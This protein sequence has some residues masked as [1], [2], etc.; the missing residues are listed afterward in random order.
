MKP[1]TDP[2]G[3]IRSFLACLIIGALPYN[4]LL[5]CL[6][7]QNLDAFPSSIMANSISDQLRSSGHAIHSATPAEVEG[8]LNRCVEATVRFPFRCSPGRLVDSSGQIS[9]RFAC[10][11]H[12]ERIAGASTEGGDIPVDNACAIIDFVEFLDI[13]G[14]RAAHQRSLVVK[15]LRR[16]ELPHI[17]SSPVADGTVCIIYAR[18][19]SVPIDLLAEE[20]S[21]LNETLEHSEWVDMIAIS[22]TAVVSYGCQFAGRSDIGDVLPPSK[23]VKQ[24]YSPAWYI[25]PT[26]QATGEGTFNKVALHI[27]GY[28]VFFVP[29]TLV[30]EFRDMQAGVGKTVITLAPYQY[31]VAGD[32]RLVPT[33]HYADRLLPSRPFLVEAA[34]SE[35]LLA[36]L[37]Y[38]P[39]QDGGVILLRGKLPLEGL[40]IFL[41]RE[42]LVR[43]G[44]VQS[45]PRSQDSYVLPIT[46]ADFQL[47]MERLRKQSN[48]VVRQVQPKYVMEKVADAGTTTPFM[49]RV[50]MGMLQLRGTAFPKDNEREE[51]DKAL[52][53][54]L[55]PLISARTAVEE[56]LRL[57]RTHM[58]DIASGRGVRITADGLEVVGD[59]HR[60]FRREIDSFLYDAAKALKE[61]MQKAGKAAGKDIGFLFQKQ[62]TYQN[63]LEALRSSDPILAQYIEKTRDR[64][65]ERLI[66]ARNNLDHGGWTL[67][68]TQY[69]VRNGTQII[70]HPPVIDGTPAAEFVAHML[71]RLSCFIEEFLTH[72]FQGRLPSGAEIT[73]IPIQWRAPQAP[74]R[75]KLTLRIGGRPAWRLLYSDRHFEEI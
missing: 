54:A 13:E 49:A 29:G 67:P 47:M 28:T 56:I 18:H 61:G 68:K 39:W 41:G 74:Q 23:G 8:V 75:F 1:P 38:I 52:D 26:M 14:L 30:S 59:F 60:S 20:F 21:R 34:K 43:G 72:C 17:N 42:A 55:T 4:P 6:H 51:F 19:A 40:L 33:E 27:A 11:V 46:Q 12:V 31:N 73:E 10:V 15:R 58:T 25:I 16:A 44:V 50:F 22:G 36:T 66:K 71:D 35:E 63:G 2:V 69:E 7:L 57:W 5:A 65:S 37:T 64:W 62:N 3:S 53:A 24:K 70:A 48:M 32:L 45:G 9:Q